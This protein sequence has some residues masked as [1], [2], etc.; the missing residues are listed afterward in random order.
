MIRSLCSRQFSPAICCFIAGLSLL[1]P[2]CQRTTDLTVLPGRVLTEGVILLDGHPLD[3]GQI[4]LIPQA[5]PEQQTDEES[6]I[7]A[8]IR[9]GKFHLQAAPGDYRVRIQKYEY[10]AKSK[11]G[12]PQLPEQY[13]QQSTLT[14]QI[15]PQGQQPLKFELSSQPVNEVS[16]DHH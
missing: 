3:T 8:T 9:Q 15:L 6:W 16:S 1:L 14:T 2:G 4:T 7:V 12:K 10:E 5:T 13:D 11:T